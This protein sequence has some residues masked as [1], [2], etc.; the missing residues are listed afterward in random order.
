MMRECEKNCIA[1]VD[2]QC[3]VEQCGGPI[4]TIHRRYTAT[5]EQAA[6][7]YVASREAFDYYFGDRKGGESP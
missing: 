1:N 3:M 4:T 5:L 2:G 7:F 6:Q